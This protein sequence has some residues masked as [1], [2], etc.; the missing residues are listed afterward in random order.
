M[1]KSFLHEIEQFSNL[2]TAHETKK[3][4]SYDRAKNKLIFAYEGGLFT[5]DP[6][7][8]LFAK[9]HDTQR[10]LILIDNNDNPVKINEIDKFIA[11]AESSY[12]EAM[13]EYHLLY[14]D[15]KK[16]RTVKKLIDE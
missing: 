1:D 8:I 2:K 4:N 15:L 6:D 13:N 16:Q 7:T 14:Q 12:Y 9:M 3:I 10:D 5:A 11:K